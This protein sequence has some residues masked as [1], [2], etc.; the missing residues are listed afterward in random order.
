MNKIGQIA[1]P[2]E[3][4]KH[5][6]GPSSGPS[7]GGFVGGQCAGY[8]N[9]QGETGYTQFQGQQ[10]NEAASKIQTPMDDG[11]SIGV[12]GSGAKPVK[13]K[14]GIASPMTTPW[15]S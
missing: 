8:G 6:I 3:S 11:T 5:D 2:H 1:T 13:G 4:L 9:N 7:E 15:G 12:T 10:H 14:S